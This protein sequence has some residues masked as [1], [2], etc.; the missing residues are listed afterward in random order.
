MLRNELVVLAAWVDGQGGGPRLKEECRRIRDAWLRV[1]FSQKEEITRR[2]VRYQQELLLE[3][4]DGSHE[5]ALLASALELNDFLLRHF[6]AHLDPDTKIPRAAMPGI[7]QRIKAA[8][9]SVRG[10]IAGQFLL[11]YLDEIEHATHLTYRE[12]DYFF[13]FCDAVVAAAEDQ[14]RWIDMLCRMNFNHSGFCKWYQA[15]LEQ[16]IRAKGAKERM[17]FLKSQL[18]NARAMPHATGLAYDPALPSVSEQTATWLFLLIQEETEAEQK[19]ALHVTVAQLALLI[20]LLVEEDFIATQQI[21]G[22]LRF[23]C[24][25]FKTR[26]QENISY[27]SMNKLYYSA[28]QFTAFAVRAM[29]QKMVARTN[30][31]FFPI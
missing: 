28:D 25:H 1:L 26:K 20:R 8:G 31:T 11:E 19:I 10:A 13:A 29:L 22:V 3:I 17:I 18:I 27:S 16:Q 14:Q 4:A 9:A 6:K 12:Q 23:F 30:K 7:R 21:A 15:R 2:Y 24:A 5:P